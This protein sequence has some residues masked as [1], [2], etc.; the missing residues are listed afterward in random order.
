MTEM[1]TTRRIL[2]TS[3]AGRKKFD[4]SPLVTEQRP[5]RPRY[6]HQL[7]LRAKNGSN[8]LVRRRRFFAEHAGHAMVEPDAF[9]LA[10]NLTLG[11]R[12]PRHLA[13]ESAASAMR[14]GVHRFRLASTFDVKAQ[15]RHR[16]RKQSE[17]TLAG[18]HCPF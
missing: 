15:S 10:M 13:A 3:R 12:A 14:A 17:R 18:R 1:K 5:Q 16:S 11:D 8:V 7:V 9:H 2:P 4:L 6:F